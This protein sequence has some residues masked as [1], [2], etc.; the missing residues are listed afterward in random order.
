MQYFKIHN[1]E[2]HPNPHKKFSCLAHCNFLSHDPVQCSAVQLQCDVSLSSSAS[3][4]FVLLLL[5][6][7]AGCCRRRRCQDGQ[8][9]LKINVE[10]LHLQSCSA[11]GCTLAKSGASAQEQEWAKLA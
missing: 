9:S 10:N 8:A 5:F 2:M 7:V 4:H 1:G 11:A 6:L 3:P